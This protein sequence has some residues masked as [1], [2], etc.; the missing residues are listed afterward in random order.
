MSDKRYFRY[1]KG[2]T[3]IESDSDNK[4]AIRL[5]YI[6]TIMYWVVRIALILLGGG[7]VAIARILIEYIDTG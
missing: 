7:T 1:R 4:D 6:N 2:R 3:K 5:A